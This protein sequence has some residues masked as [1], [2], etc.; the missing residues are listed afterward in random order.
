[1][2]YVLDFRIIQKEIFMNR[3]QL[4]L[5]L[6]LL[7]QTAWINSVFKNNN[8]VSTHSDPISMNSAELSI[9]SPN[10]ELNFKNFFLHKENFN[11]YK[12]AQKISLMEDYSKLGCI[13]INSPCGNGSTHLAHAIGNKLNLMNPNKKIHIISSEK[14]MNQCVRHYRSNEMPIFRKFYRE[15]LDILVIDS[16]QYIQN[17]EFVQTEL[18]HTFKSIA[19][20]GGL[21]IVTTDS[22]IDKM[23]LLNKNLAD[24]IQGGI[25]LKIHSPSIQSRLELLKYFSQEHAVQI[26][27]QNTYKIAKNKIS[28]RALLGEIKKLK[29]I[30]T[31]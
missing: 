31:I 12:M 16:F 7:P 25:E 21:V 1:M 8:S 13:V 20:R 30:E 10:N 17:G 5:G 15:S 29:L 9:S 19:D 14:L 2:L 24:Y 27:P 3:R 4:I 6:G 18:L 26:N 23:P 11:A 22:G 28:T